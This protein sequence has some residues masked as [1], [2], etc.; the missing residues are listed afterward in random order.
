MYL[1]SHI[2]VLFQGLLCKLKSSNCPTE[3][4]EVGI[5]INKQYTTDK[6]SLIN[7]KI[8]LSERQTDPNKNLIRLQ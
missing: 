5:F 8:S 2:S 7:L 1:I 4:Y 6:V 3:Q